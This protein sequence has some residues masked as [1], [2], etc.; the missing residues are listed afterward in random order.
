MRGGMSS[1]ASA[2]APMPQRFPSSL[3][4]RIGA[5]A[6][7]SSAKSYAGT[8]SVVRIPE[9]L[10]CPVRVAVVAWI[11]RGREST[12]LRSSA[13]SVVTVS[14][15][16][17]VRVSLSITFAISI[18]FATWSRLFFAWMSSIWDRKVCSCL[19]RSSRRELKRESS[20]SRILPEGVASSL[21]P[22]FLSTDASSLSS[23]SWSVGGRSSSSCG[24]CGSYSTSLICP[25][26]VVTFSPFAFPPSI[27]FLTEDNIPAIF[28][29][30]WELRAR[31]QQA[32]KRTQLRPHGS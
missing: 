19:I 13:N 7:M 9:R 17:R 1:V 30:K 28:A 6:R 12:S 25:L 23:S 16:S 32:A 27:L 8:N 22:F 2:A 10:T 26:L 20:L 3:V 21:S 29:V 24:F 11:S 14:R 5:G 15:R 31:F 4:S 18:C